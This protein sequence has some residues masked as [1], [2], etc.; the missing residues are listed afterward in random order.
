MK[1]PPAVHLAQFQ[2]KYPQVARALKNMFAGAEPQRANDDEERARTAELNEIIGG[3][4]P[5]DAI[6][7]SLWS[8]VHQSQE[9][10]FE[11]SVAAYYHLGTGDEVRA[12]MGRLWCAALHTWVAP[13][14]E[15]F[16]GRVVEQ[17]RVH[18]FE[19]LDFCAPIFREVEI[20][21][22]FMLRWIRD[23]RRAVGND[24]Y[25]RGLFACL[26]NY[27]RAQPA[28]ALSVLRTAAAQRNDSQTR[29]TFAWMLHYCRD[30]VTG[31]LEDQ[32]AEIECTLASPG[33]AAS[34]SMLL[35]SWAFSAGNRR[36]SESQ[37][38]ALRD[39]LCR[40]DEDEAAAWSFLLARVV[41]AEQRDWSWAYRE[42]DKLKATPL[43][44]QARHWA[45]IAVFHG[46]VASNE[47][48]AFPPAQW[49]ELFFSFPPLTESDGGVWRE[50]DYRL[51]EGLQTRPAI[52]HT[53]IVRLAETAGNA[54]R[55]L[56]KQERGF[57]NLWSHALKSAAQASAIV[58]ALCLSPSRQARR[59]GVNLLS[60]VP[61]PPL[62]MA[63]L[64]AAKP[65][66]LE[67]ILLEASLRL[68]DYP[69]TARL[70]ACMAAHIDAVGGDLSEYFYDEVLTQALNTNQYRE[71]IKSSAAQHGKIQ[72]IIADAHQRLDATIAAG[73]SPALQMRVPGRS[74]AES[75]AARR[76]GRQLSK[77]VDEFSIIKQFATTVQLLYG[78]TWRM[79]DAAGKL[80]APSSLQLSSVSM[81]M[82][83]LEFVTPDAMRLRR[84][85]AARRIAEIQGEETD[86]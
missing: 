8:D 10:F 20:A 77:S 25:Q 29:G 44:A 42:L 1:F 53:F 54:W 74:R 35:E 71:T 46:W 7:S 9:R 12:F 26:E 80:T 64:A 59:V 23:A 67:L 79:Q 21:P 13:A 68:L 48:A 22:D 85:A 76:F 51:R 63:A 37:A 15:E 6:F 2:E 27:A 84:L 81:E 3:S 30:S 39:Q 41:D 40:G 69:Q 55:K 14:R 33:D 5:L 70:H 82:P 38:Q 86:E 24:L 50:L 52:T 45:L 78:K 43:A 28:A 66:Q 47:H 61:D 17:Q 65:H 73:K 83:R 56:L 34:R 49:S 18:L 72:S 16:L 32:L 19:A 57:M 4:V 11:C 62:D 36:L 75:L 58:T 31:G 60:T